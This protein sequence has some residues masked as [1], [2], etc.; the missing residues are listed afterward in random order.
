MKVADDLLKQ[1]FDLVEKV[2]TNSIFEIYKYQ[3]NKTDPYIPKYYDMPVDFFSGIES[4]ALSTW[5]EI[6]PA[7]NYGIKLYTYSD[8]SGLKKYGELLSTKDGQFNINI[9]KIDGFNELILIYSENED[10]NAMKWE[11][12]SMVYSVLV[13]IENIVNRYLYISKKFS[14]GEID[15]KILQEL[16]ADQLIRI[17]SENLRVSICVPICF[18]V[19]DEDII[20][21]ADNISICKMSDEFQLGRA[22]ACKFEATQ[23]NYITQCAGYMI[24]LSGY[25]LENKDRNSLDNAKNNY[26]AYPIEL[27]DDFFAAIRVVTGANTGYGQLLIE[28]IEWADNWTADYLPIYGTTFRRFNR[29]DERKY[30]EYKFERIQKEDVEKVIKV[31]KEIRIQRESKKKNNPFKKVLIAIKRMNRC[32]LREEDDDTALDAIIGIETILSGNTQ[33]EITYT[34]SNRM[35]VVA[36]KME[37]C[38]YSSTEARNAMKTI[39]GLRSD[40]V[41]G[42]DTDKNAKVKISDAEIDTKKLAI[43]FLRYSLLFVIENQDY[44]DVRKFEEALDDA[45]QNCK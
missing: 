19:F 43:D 23:E 42:R 29:K 34:I 4:E 25:N 20:E 22:K 8:F 24:K 40:I 11:K 2:C 12:D 13:F 37:K 31:F 41:H 32:M 18:L 9:T 1:I 3:E 35:S 38:P 27:I 45:M 28:P 16:I 15:K 10:A 33:G 39:Y 26:W 7:L 44:L 30:W 6:A 17:Y 21:I 36:A 5:K 14:E